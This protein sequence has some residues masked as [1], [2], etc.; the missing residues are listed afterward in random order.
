[1][2]IAN[3]GRHLFISPA[4]F[5][6]VT[7][8]NDMKMTPSDKRLVVDETSDF[9]IL[10]RDAKQKFDWT[11]FSN[12]QHSPLTPNNGELIRYPPSQEPWVITRRRHS[13]G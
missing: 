5:T 3:I 1:M 12:T 7:A 2:A 4:C 6:V 11:Q 13:G 10:C 9:C 8:I